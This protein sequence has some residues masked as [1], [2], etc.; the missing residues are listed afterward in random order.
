MILPRKKPNLQ[1]RSKCNFRFISFRAAR[2]HK[3][4][5]TPSVAVVFV[6]ISGRPR[7]ILPITVVTDVN[8]RLMSVCLS[9]VVPEYQSRSTSLWQPDSIDITDNSFFLPLEAQ[10]SQHGSEMH[11]HFGF[12]FTSPRGYCNVDFHPMV[13]ARHLPSSLQTLVE[14]DGPHCPYP[15]AA[16]CYFILWVLYLPYSSIEVMPRA[17]SGVVRIDPLCF[18]AGCC[19]RRL[20]QA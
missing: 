14:S 8:P 10:Y 20:N 5:P 11:L 4:V 15:Q 6:P 7:N 1:R 16:F 17:G 19:T 2:W 13:V 3:F 12:S 9:L 18:L